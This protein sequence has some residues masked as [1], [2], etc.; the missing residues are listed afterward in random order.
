M[1]ARQMSERRCGRPCAEGRGRTLV[2]AQQPL[3]PLHLDLA[4]AQELEVGRHDLPQPHEL[5]P[6]YRLL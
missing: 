5:L 4:R 2:L 6:V 1:D 3:H